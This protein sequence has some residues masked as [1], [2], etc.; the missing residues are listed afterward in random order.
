MSGLDRVVV[1]TDDVRVMEAVAGL[2][3]DCCLTE[4]APTGTDRVAGV[5][6]RPEYRAAQWFVNVQG[7]EPLVPEAAVSG[8]L[9][10]VRSGAFGLATA[11]VRLERGELEDPNVTKVWVDGDG[12]ALG[13]GR[14]PTEDVIRR[15]VVLRHVG[16]YA[17]AAPALQRWSRTEQT[18]EERRERL[19]QLRPLGYGEP[20]GVASLDESAPRGIDTAEDLAVVEAMFAQFSATSERVSS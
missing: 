19:E 20:M 8:A 4:A 16:V 5:A 13:F 3:V 6:R 15:H 11:A 7:D 10:L 18:T 1:A 12:R 9:S 17:Y 2:G 14:T